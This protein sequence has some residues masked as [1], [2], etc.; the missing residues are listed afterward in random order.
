MLV[1]GATDHLGDCDGLAQSNPLY[2]L[3]EIGDD[4]WSNRAV[5]PCLAL[6]QLL[7]CWEATLFPAYAQ[8]GVSEPDAREEGSRTSLQE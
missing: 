1:K 4:I 8:T 2:D 5:P 3:W 7:P 6:P